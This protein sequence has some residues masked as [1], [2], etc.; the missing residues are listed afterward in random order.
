[1]GVASGVNFRIANLRIF[2]SLCLLTFGGRY[3]VNLTA[4]GDDTHGA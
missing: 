4:R 3:D 1:M 2:E